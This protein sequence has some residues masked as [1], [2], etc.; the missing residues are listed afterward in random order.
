[1]N[2]TII[3]QAMNPYFDIAEKTKSGAMKFI[4]NAWGVL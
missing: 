3:L 4:D 2:W 1:V